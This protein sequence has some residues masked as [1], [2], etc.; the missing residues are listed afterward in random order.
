M[1]ISG[2]QAVAA[3]TKGAVFE[4]DLPARLDRLPW[5][6]F[7]TLLGFAP[8]ITWLLVGPE[9]TLAGPGS[10][11]F[12]DSSVIHRSKACSGSGGGAYF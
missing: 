7:H 9:V 6:R 4:T 3:D 1:A 11:A 8:G 10:R 5:G 2:V 12:Y